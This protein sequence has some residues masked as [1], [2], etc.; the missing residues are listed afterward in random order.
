[1]AGSLVA[2]H[3]M[4]EPLLANRGEGQRARLLEGMTQAV[5]EK[6][7]YEAT[8]ADAVRIARVSRGT[9][10]A[11][12]TSKESCFLEAHRHGVDVLIARVAAS[13]RSADGD[14]LARMRAGLR[15]LLAALV[16]EPRFARTYLL[17]INAAGA[18]A[19]AARDEAL[20]RFAQ[21][22]GSSFL[23]ATEERPELRIPTDDL[24]FILAAGADQLIC[25][26][27]RADPHADL[28][29]LED[30]IVEAALALLEGASLSP[31]KT[32]GS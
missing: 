32:G 29:A 20:R 22:Y 7:Y 28:L 14:W 15:T 26:K 30:P 5:Y 21:R 2:S 3:P 11:L 6:G 17:E 12:F 8:V 23:A 16:D 31:E 25:A 1:M 27:L 18:R 4:L 10:Y 24:L 9:F 13:A 19:Q